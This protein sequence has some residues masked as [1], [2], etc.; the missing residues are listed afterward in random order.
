MLSPSALAQ[1]ANHGCAAAHYKVIALPFHPVRISNSGVVAGTTEDHQP[2][3]WTEKGGLRE[4]DFPESFTAAEVTGINLAGDIVGF[5]TKSGSSQTFAFRFSKGKFALLSEAT[6]KAAAINGSSDVAGQNAEHLVVW[7][8]RKMI[9]LGGCCGGIAHGMNNGGEVVGELN[10]KQGRYGAFLWDSV[11]GLRSIAPPD[12]SRS[13]ALAINEAGHVLIQ[14]FTPTAVFLRE[15]D[16]LK[17]V[18]LSNEVASQPLALNNCDVIVGEF[19]VASDFYHAFI[20]DKK[21]GLR[22]LNTLISTGFEWRLASA[23]DINDRGEIIGIGA[24][25]DDG[26]AGFLLT[27]DAPE[28]A[29]KSP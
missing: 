10:D 27:P 18:Q 11:R 17:P 8:K 5:A 14:S 4:I 15:R 9:S 25:S 2:A 7:R 26:D 21:D 28:H 13:I 6:S 19:G 29:T 23:T 20:W 1:T 24:H 22:D 16:T 12:S 3:A